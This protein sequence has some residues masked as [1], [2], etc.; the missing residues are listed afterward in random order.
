MPLDWAFAVVAIGVIGVLPVLANELPFGSVGQV[1][2]QI[3]SYLG[4]AVAFMAG[5][6]I[7][8]RYSPDRDQPRWQWVSWG[9][10]IATVVWILASVAFTLY[11]QNFGSYGETYGSLSAVIVLMLWLVITAF[12]VILGAELNSELEAQ[13]AKD[14]TVGEPQPMGQRDAVKADNIAPSQR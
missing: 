10:V 11:V 2:V 7:L 8:Y 13:T 4:L 12:A 6:A 3:A 1:L 9:A 14:S 5:L